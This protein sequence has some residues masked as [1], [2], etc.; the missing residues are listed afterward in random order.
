MVSML[1]SNGGGGSNGHHIKTKPLERVTYMQASTALA[2]Y[3]GQVL[4]TNV[5]IVKPPRKG[6]DKIVLRQLSQKVNWNQ[7]YAERPM[8]APAKAHHQ[9]NLQRPDGDIRELWL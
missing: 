2:L 3:H 5:L 7:M 1:V 6:L 8:V 9:L 4:G